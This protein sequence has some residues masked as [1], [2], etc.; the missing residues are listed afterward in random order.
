MLFL[1]L[2]VVADALTF[3]RG[4]KCSII[5]HTVHYSTSSIGRGHSGSAAA[6]SF[7]R[8][9]LPN[10][11]WGGQIAQTAASKASNSSSDILETE[12]GDGAQSFDRM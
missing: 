5:T 2:V 9:A 7:V 8:R 10:R 11:P 12:E 1:L 3:P 4:P 6:L